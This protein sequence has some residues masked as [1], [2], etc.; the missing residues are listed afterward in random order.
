MRIIHE[1][2]P[3]PVN[4]LRL[5]R[6]SLKL[7]QRELGRRIDLSESVI[8][9][10]EAGVYTRPNDKLIEFL[11]AGIEISYLEWTMQIRQL[12]APQILPL[13][14]RAT[15]AAG[16][17]SSEHPFVIF[18]TALGFP[19]RM[20]FCKFA[21]VHQGSLFKYETGQ[22]RIMPDQLRDWFLESHIPM[23][24][25]LK[26]VIYTNAWQE[27]QRLDRLTKIPA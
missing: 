19:A 4:P 7:T 10:N 26:L 1:K 13:I 21:L 11:G 16:V 9:L 27:Q 15:V 17:P 12:R 3:E 23:E 22:Q 18:R 8:L 6:L 20:T 25:R 24:Y 2:P 5:A 14:D